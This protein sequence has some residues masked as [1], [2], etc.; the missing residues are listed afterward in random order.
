MYSIWDKP[1]NKWFQ[2]VE[3]MGDNLI[4]KILVFETEDQ[5][6][7][8]MQYFF[9]ISDYTYEHATYRTNIYSIYEIRPVELIVKQKK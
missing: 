1:N 9:K 2:T 3:T 7:T 4:R 6:K 5:V 8:W